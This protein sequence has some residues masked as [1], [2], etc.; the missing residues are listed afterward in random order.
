MWNVSLFARRQIVIRK[1]ARRES[2][3][4]LGA[5]PE[6][7]ILREK[8]VVVVERGSEILSSSGEDVVVGRE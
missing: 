7:L 3:G 2:F 1:R 5:S 6:N 4:E 8:R